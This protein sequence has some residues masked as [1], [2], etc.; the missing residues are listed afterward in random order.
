MGDTKIE[1]IAKEVGFVK[2]SSSRL[3]GR[4]F[5]EMNLNNVGSAGKGAMSLTEKTDYLEERH[6][7]SMRKQSLTKRYNDYSVQFMRRCAEALMS[8]FLESFKDISGIQSVFKAIKIVDA[9]SFKLPSA[10]SVYYRGNGDAGGSAGVKIHQSYELLKGQLL[11]FHVTDSKQSDASYW[12]TE[13]LRIEAEELF[14]ADL[15][16][17]KLANLQKIA[18][19]KA[20]FISRYKTGVNLYVKDEQGQLKALDLASCLSAA[21]G[22]IDLPE[23]YMGANESVRVRMVIV[24]LPDEVKKMRIKKLQAHAANTSKKRKQW[25]VSEDR[26]HYVG[27]TFL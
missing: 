15:G 21:K 9:T 1:E 24:P 22:A 17:F 12:T 8:S 4:M 2:R 7:L 5:L 3:N 11:D 27:L 18:A 6:G 25:Q 26:R 20:Y 16:Y 10:F 13:N 23:V 19:N 14:I